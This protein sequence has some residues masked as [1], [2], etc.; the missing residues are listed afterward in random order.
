MVYGPNVMFMWQKRNHSLQG[1]CFAEQGSSLGLEA[2]LLPSFLWLTDS[3]GGDGA[4]LHG[5]GTEARRP[6]GDHVHRAPKLGCSVAHAFTFSRLGS[7]NTT[8]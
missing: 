6:S 5:G 2:A 4:P 7:Y 1:F 3:T 8:I